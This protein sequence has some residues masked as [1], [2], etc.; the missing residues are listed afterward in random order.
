MQQTLYTYHDYVLQQRKDWTTHKMAG[1]RQQQKIRIL[2]KD[3]A[4]EIR[5]LANFTIQAQSCIFNTP[6]LNQTIF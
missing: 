4:S 1:L 3:L 6:T 5:R 2:S